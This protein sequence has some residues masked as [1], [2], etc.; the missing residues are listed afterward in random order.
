MLCVFQWLVFFPSLFLF[1]HLLFFLKK[2][3]SFDPHASIIHSSVRH[4]VADLLPRPSIQRKHWK[5]THSTD[6]IFQMSRLLLISVLL[7]HFMVFSVSYGICAS[8]SHSLWWKYIWP[9]LNSS[10]G[11]FGAR[12]RPNKNEKKQRRQTVQLKREGKAMCVS[13]ALAIFPWT[14]WLGFFQT[15]P[16]HLLTEWKKEWQSGERGSEQM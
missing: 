6:W 3:L 1:K 16:V 2:Q 15:G 13:V 12:E 9:Q 14:H 11:L 5:C 8:P 10:G 7:K 4:S